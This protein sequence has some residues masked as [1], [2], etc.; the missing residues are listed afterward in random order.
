MHSHLHIH[1]SLIAFLSLAV[2]LIVN[3][4]VLKKSPSGDSPAKKRYRRFI[5]GAMVFHAVDAVWGI[6]D[7]LELRIPL[8]IT[9]VTFFLVMAFSVLLWTKLVIVYLGSQYKFGKVLYVIGWTFFA[10]QTVALIVNFFVPVFFKIVQTETEFSYISLPIRYAAFQTQII[11]FVLTAVFALI[12][13]KD[14]EHGMR[15][16]YYAIA[17]FGAFM[18]GA[19]V[20]QCFFPFEPFY[21]IGYMLGICI[22]HTF[23]V[24]EEIMARVKELNDSLSREEEQLLMIN[25]A[26]KR[27]LVDPLTGAGSMNAFMEVREEINHSIKEGECEDFAVIMLDVNDL[28]MINDT[29]GRETGDQF[30][31]DAVKLMSDSFKQ[32]NVYRIGG[33]EFVIILEDMDFDGRKLLFDKFNKRV[34]ANIH[35]GHVVIAAGMSAYNSDN[36]TSFGEIFI[37]AEM[38]MFR[39][40]KEL[41]R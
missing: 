20:A 41:K 14:V 9:T 26:K 4:D 12:H 36:D 27:A 23:V 34:E 19:I 25:E 32:S 29:K 1:Y 16:R 3:L 33:D 39:R 7:A 30:L 24:E 15:K 21:S 2:L 11:M 28:H 10:L 31:I 22:I 8:Y 38:Q 17:L 40:K 35:I 6:L 5:Y 18:V 37:R 13:S